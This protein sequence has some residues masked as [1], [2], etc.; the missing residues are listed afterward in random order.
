MIAQVQLNNELDKV[1]WRLST[2]ATYTS[3]SAYWAQFLGSHAD[4]DWKQIWKSNVESKCRFF[5]WL[6]L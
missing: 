4:Y 6:L 3:K 2:T 5:T 1:F